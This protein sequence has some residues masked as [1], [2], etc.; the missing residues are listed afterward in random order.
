MG[1]GVGQSILLTFSVY[2]VVHCFILAWFKFYFLLFL[3]MVIDDSEFERKGVKFKPM[4][5]LN[6]NIYVK[7]NPALPLFCFNVKT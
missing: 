4:I 3:G 2:F 6:H 5:K 1:V 7:P